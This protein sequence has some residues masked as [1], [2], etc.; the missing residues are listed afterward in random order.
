[1]HITPPHGAP[2]PNPAP[3]RRWRP[4][5]QKQANLATPI[6]TGSIVACVDKR[7]L[8]VG[9][10]RCLGGHCAQHGARQ[11]SDRVDHVWRTW[12]RLTLAREVARETELE[13]RET[14]RQRHAFM[15]A[16]P[17]TASAAAICVRAP[18]ALLQTHKRTNAPATSGKVRGSVITCVWFRLPPT[19]A[20][21]LVAMDG[22]NSLRP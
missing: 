9:A 20:S 7:G 19:A 21:P 6:L 2:G 10:L 3:S 1:M 13:I 14:D 5:R 12:P 4:E 17:L 22:R 16:D 15:R 18:A 11:A 8:A